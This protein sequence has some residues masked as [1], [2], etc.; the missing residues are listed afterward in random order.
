MICMDH[1]ATSFPKPPSVLRAVARTMGSCANPG[2]GGHEAARNADRVV[3][4]CREEA[5]ALFG[6][7]PEQ[8]YGTVRSYSKTYCRDA[9]GGRRIV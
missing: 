2:R 1:G 8:Y 6:C 9:R 4:G 7:R 5:A 3:Y